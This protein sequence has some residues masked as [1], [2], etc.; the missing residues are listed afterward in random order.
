MTPCN[1]PTVARG[2]P[3]ESE[4]VPALL[5]WFDAH[6]RPLPWRG[7][8][9]WGVLVSEVMLQ[10]TPVDRVRPIWAEWMG[11]WPQ[12]ADLATAGPA[13]A[14]RA[15]GRLG[16]PRRAVRLQAAA[17][18]ICRD[19]DG[20]VPEEDDA[21]RTLPGVGS[22]TAAAVRAFAFG[23]RSLVLDTNV[24]RVVAR[25]FAG[26]AEPSTHQTAAERAHADELWPH[27]EDRSARWSAAVMEFGALV[28]QARCPRCDGCAVRDNCSWTLAGQPPPATR[29][30]RQAP[31][32]GSDRQARG[33]I[34][35]A[36]RQA[37]GPVPAR[38]VTRA[39]P[40]AEQRDRAVASLLED[41]LAVRLT[42]RRYA[43]P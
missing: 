15:W 26:V 3:E 33:R 23:R 14:I 1:D 12:P 18:V 21:L 32:A 30:R 40:D 39:W 7:S 31:Y 19:F 37:N 10:Q 43:L 22:Y 17:V 36:L 29:P 5:A 35:Q 38:E 42:G 13:A 9:P 28:C 27:A 34:L 8:S 2:G 11:R 6:E 4:V 25:V 20:R 24:R 41:G 16:Y